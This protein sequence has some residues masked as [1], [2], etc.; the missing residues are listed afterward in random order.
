[1]SISKAIDAFN[2]LIVINNDRIDGYS[3]VAD[4]MKDPG[5]KQFFLDL[6]HTSIICRNELIAEVRRMGG[7]PDEYSGATGKFFR[8]WIKIKAALGGDDINRIIALCEREENV[9]LD[10]YKNV[11]IQEVNEIRP[12]EQEVL[13]NQY[14][15]LKKDYEKVKLIVMD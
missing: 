13:N 2:A 9:A 7:I 10:A 12:R 14:A 1:M 11:L 6:C 8:A 5:L 15:L 3:A 4:E